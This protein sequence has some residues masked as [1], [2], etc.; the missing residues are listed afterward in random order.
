LTVGP[1]AF[2]VRDADVEAFRSV[3]QLDIDDEWPGLGE[4]YGLATN[5]RSQ[6]E[7]KE[8][9]IQELRR[10]RKTASQYSSAWMFCSASG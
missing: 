2:P 3:D 4:F 8:R 1:D 9:V 5:L 6:L 7:A 10:P